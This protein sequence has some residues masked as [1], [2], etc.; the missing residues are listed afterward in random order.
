MK[1]LLYCAFLLAA[2]GLLAFEEKNILLDTDF[3]GAPEAS[4]GTI[5]AWDVKN[6]DV[7]HNPLVLL[8]GEAP[9]GK[10]AVR[11]TIPKGEI[12]RQR[13]ITLVAGEKYRFGAY[14]R[15]K[16]FKS[17]TATIRIWNMGWTRDLVSSRIP[18]D[19]NGRW[20][21]VEGTG[22]APQSRDFY[23]YG[24]YAEAPEGSIDFACPYLIPLSEKALAGSKVKPPTHK[25][26][27]DLSRIVP[28]EPL[29]TK[30]DVT[31]PRMKFYVPGGNAAALADCRLGVQTRMAGAADYSPWSFF[32][33]GADRFADARLGKLPEGEGKLRVGL[34]R[35]GG[36]DPVSQNEYAI[37]VVTLPPKSS[38]KPLNNLVGEILETELKDGEITFINPREG[39]V[40]IGFDKPFPGA[41]ATIDGNKQPSVKF[42]EGEASECMN[43]LSAGKHTLH[44]QG[45]P[46]QGGRLTVRTVP[47][48]MIYP[49]MIAQ[50]NDFNNYRYDLDFYKKHIFHA[51]NLF[52]SAYWMPKSPHDLTVDRELAERGIKVVSSH[53]LNSL[54]DEKEVG[55]MAAAIR[56]N[57]YMLRNWGLAADEIDVGVMPARSLAVAEA[58][59]ALAD[60]DRRLGLWFCGV[61]G[62]LFANPRIHYNL[63]S[64]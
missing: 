43:V 40:F 15:T 4:P 7:P 29:L 57:Q 61:E 24:I 20:V 47:E 48:I 25:G 12:F 14:V 31:A 13:D 45:A 8:P 36:K 19:T 2:S 62:N 55:R 42:R 44:I 1:K 34:F 63:L 41:T 30:I 60:V 51:S 21:K 35:K 56:N 10:N 3:A 46:A 23:T 53:P 38:V 17:K 64:A 32:D 37:R 6:Q 33:I 22:I 27:L 54:K 59:W 9:D 49:L 58:F 18:G 50:K 11:V 5:G 39:W 26:A 28:V 16:G 52:Q